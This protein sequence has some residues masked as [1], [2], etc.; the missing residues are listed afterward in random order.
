[1]Q[2]VEQLTGWFGGVQV[3]EFARQS[4]FLR[5]T[6]KKLT[7]WLF[8]QGAVLLV[9]QSAVSLSRWAAMLGV[10]SGTRLAKQSLWERINAGAVEFLQL[11]LGATI[12]KRVHGGCRSV[13][14]ALQA[15]QRVLIQD[16]TTIQ[17]TE[18]LAAVFPGSSNQRGPKNGLLKIQ[19]VYELLTQRFVS[20]GLS[21]FTRND[22]TAARDI[23]PLLQPGDLVLR[24]L[25]YF[26]IQTFEQIV[27]AG[28]FFLSRVRLD[29]ALRD[30]LTGNEFNLLAELKRQGHLDRN[31]LV[32]PQKMPVRLVA[33]RLPPA[34]A[35]ERRRKAKMNRDQRCKPNARSLQL[36]GWAIFITNVPSDVWSAKTVAQVYG[37]R[38]RIET[39][40]KAWK[41]HFRLTETPHGSEFQLRTV[42]Y[43]RLLFITVLA[44]VGSVGWLEPWE[45][46]RRPPASLLK[47]AA[48]MGQFILLLCLEAWKIKTT[49]A[50]LLQF[51]YHGRYDSRGRKNFVEKLRE[52]S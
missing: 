5:R 50:V 43:A 13:P 41:S 48:L 42:I 21:G 23:L 10:L 6:A 7:P 12:A 38:W 36:L 27:Q 15:F 3:G 4:R 52:L 34:V 17:L 11:I 29:L 37:L 18:R 31:V 16:S 39:I 47:I 2:C 14:K 46:S 44:Q 40:F 26:V 49:D 35:A 33:L 28:A 1:M 9:S 51:D 25:G 19:A 20:F 24:D 30:G 32:G 8:L 22:Q 45:H